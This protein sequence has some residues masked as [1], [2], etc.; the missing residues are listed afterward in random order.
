M[1]L[2]SK[3]ELPFPV[4]PP[5]ELLL[6]G[7]A[8]SKALASCEVPGTAEAPAATS[9]VGVLVTELPVLLSLLL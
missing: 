4:A 8:S 7:P 9:T 3:E 6:E 2:G 1:L 5:E